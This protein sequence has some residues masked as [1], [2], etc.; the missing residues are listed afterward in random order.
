MLVIMIKTIYM[1]LNA[2]LASFDECKIAELK[3]V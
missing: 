3:K 2:A 1:T